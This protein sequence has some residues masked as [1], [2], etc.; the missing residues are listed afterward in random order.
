[1]SKQQQHPV[2]HNQL[3]NMLLK[4]HQANKKMKNIFLFFIQI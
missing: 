3:I 1:M 4:T 2:K